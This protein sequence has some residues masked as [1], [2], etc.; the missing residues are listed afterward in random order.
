MEAYDSSQPRVVASGSSQPRVVASGSSQPRVEASGSSQPRV[1][2]SDNV[3]LSV[4]G[5]VKV[6]ASQHVATLAEGEL[7]EIQGGIMRR[8]TLNT[9]RDWCGYYGAR[10]Q[11]D[12]A[13]LYKAVDDNFKSGHGMAY[14]PGTAVEAPD[15]DGGDR[16]CGGG[17]HFCARPI[18]ARGYDQS[19]TKFVACRVALADIR[20]PKSDDAHPNKV[21]ARSCDAL[22]ECDEIG[23]AV[24]PAPA[25]A[26]V[27]A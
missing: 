15:W 14:L 17:L 24:E 22:Y 21:K 11:G 8:L 3:L 19:A 16:E 25:S 6:T 4:R 23:E 10:V 26:K 9:A 27:A 5:R 13:I 7:P 18:T 20:P 12:F 2:A 1:E